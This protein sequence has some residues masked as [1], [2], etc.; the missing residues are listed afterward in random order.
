M[1]KKNIT[2]FCVVLE[3]VRKGMIYYKKG[4]GVTFEYFDGSNVVVFTTTL[5]DPEHLSPQR[6]KYWTVEDVDG[7]LTLQPLRR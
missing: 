7:S 1:P 5:P 2:E 4:R 6:W 3:A